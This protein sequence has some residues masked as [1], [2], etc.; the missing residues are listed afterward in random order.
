M[1]SRPGDD[2]ADLMRAHDIAALAATL[3]SGDRAQKH[4]DAAL[5]HANI[6]TLWTAYLAIRRAPDKPLSGADVARMMALL[7]I[8]RTQTG[9]HNPDDAVDGCGYVAIAGELDN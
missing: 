9:E 6:A 7:K 1:V 4:G 8:A 5:N 3:V 2:G